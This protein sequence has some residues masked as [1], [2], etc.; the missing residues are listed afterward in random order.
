MTPDG[1]DAVR[2]GEVRS[3]HQDR[4]PAPPVLDPRQLECFIAVAEELNLRRAASAAL[5]GSASAD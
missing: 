2:L 5:H 4:G 1:P 3:L